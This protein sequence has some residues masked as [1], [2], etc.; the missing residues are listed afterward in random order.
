MNALQILQLIDAADATLASSIAIYRGVRD[1]LS[2]ED[3]A[4]ID[5]RLA[6]L[7]SSNDAAFARVDGKLE[8]AASILESAGLLL[9][10]LARNGA[11]FD[12]ALGAE[13]G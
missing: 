11:G 6:A 7:Q 13:V 3:V 10:G 5:A 1:T 9:M 2:T 12:L 8:Q 4:T